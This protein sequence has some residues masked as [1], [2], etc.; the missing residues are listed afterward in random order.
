VNAT[1]VRIG[2]TSFSNR[3]EKDDKSKG[4]HKISIKVQIEG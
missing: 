1:K 3:D 2:K 4:R